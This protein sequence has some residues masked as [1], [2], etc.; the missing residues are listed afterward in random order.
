MLQYAFRIVLRFY[1]LYNLVEAS[2]YCW[3]I[4]III[5]IIIIMLKVHFFQC[6]A[7]IQV[8]YVVLP[9]TSSNELFYGLQT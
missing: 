4:I 1:E 2:L 3:L 5:I 8:P 7:T 9:E 6:N